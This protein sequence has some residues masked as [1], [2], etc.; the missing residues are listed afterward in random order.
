V[1]K[2]DFIFMA[3]ESLRKKKKLEEDE[4][5][6]KEVNINLNIKVN[7][8]EQTPQVIPSPSG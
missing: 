6:A 7:G 8:Q 1:A 4:R 5:K 2:D 3:L